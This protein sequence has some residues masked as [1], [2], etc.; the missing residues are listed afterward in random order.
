[1]QPRPRSLPAIRIRTPPTA[2]RAVALARA[3]CYDTQGRLL[4]D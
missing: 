1:M 4:I 2:L 3:G